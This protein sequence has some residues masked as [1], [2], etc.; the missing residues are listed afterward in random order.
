MLATRLPVR[1]R[2][3]STLDV[4]LPWRVAGVRLA[5][6]P[7]LAI[8]GAYFPSRDRAPAKL[9]KKEAFIQSFLASLRQLPQSTRDTLIIAGDYNAVSRRHDPPRSGFVPCEYEL[10]DELDRLGFLS[11]HELVAFPAQPYSWIGRTGRGYLYDYFHV[12]KALQA[13]LKSCSYLHDLRELR[14]S[15]HAAVAVAVA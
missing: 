15:D 2:L 8:L 10:H 11:G 6:D 7:G 13:S 9:A 1:D 3:C 5:M 4:T 14:L 12:G